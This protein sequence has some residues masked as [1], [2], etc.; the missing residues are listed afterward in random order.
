MKVSVVLRKRVLACLGVAIGFGSFLI[1]RRAERPAVATPVRKDVPAE[2]IKTALFAGGC[3]WSVE[4]PFEELQ[5][6]I[7]SESGYAGGRTKDPTYD[8]VSNG[9]TGHIETVRVTFDD[10]RVKYED[11]VEIFWRTIDP[12]DEGGQFVDRGESYVTAIFV[13]DAE[14]RDIAEASK[15]SL[16]ESKRF[17]A[18]IVTP[19]RDA[20]TFYLAED[21]HQNFYKTNPTRYQQCSIG[22]GRDEFLKKVWGDDLKYEPKPLLKTRVYSKPSDAEI[23]TKLTPLQYK[24]TQKED[25][26]RPYKN[27][28]FDKKDDGIYVDIVSGEP[29]FSSRDKYDSGTGWPSFVRPLDPE[30][31]VEKV[32]RN[33]FGTR[34]EVR[35]KHADSH[36]GHVFSDGPKPTGLRYCMNSAALRFIPVADLE[37]EGFDEYTK[38]F[39]KPKK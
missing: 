23:K 36:L 39:S 2:Y 18:P 24:V 12:T 27:E 16:E 5:G 3:F 17:K 31:F 21:Y 30:N 35:S 22:S 7:T 29:L 9:D 37:E 6:V 10:R 8:D 34:T 4:K 11:L 15:Q 28:Y 38:L 1:L 32:D 13:A 33:L 26:E 20:A 14:Q 19:I 25:T